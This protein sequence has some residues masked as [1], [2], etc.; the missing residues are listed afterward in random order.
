MGRPG[1]R[2][3][4][5][6][7]QDHQLPKLKVQFPYPATQGASCLESGWPLAGHPSPDKE[8]KKHTCSSAQAEGDVGEARRPE[9]LGGH[10][11]YLEIGNLMR[12]QGAEAD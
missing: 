2:P 11:S 9:N 1:N 5:S 4:S 3:S 7:C 12:G 6:L 8:L 10:P